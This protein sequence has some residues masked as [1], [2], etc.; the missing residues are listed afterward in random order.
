LFWPSSYGFS[1][2]FSLL[3]LV[4]RTAFQSARL[5]LRVF[6]PP[7]HNKGSFFS[8]EGPPFSGLL[9]GLGIVGFF[10]R[11]DPPPGTSGQILHRCLALPLDTTFSSS[12]QRCGAGRH[13]LSIFGGLFFYLLF[14]RRSRRGLLVRPFFFFFLAAPPV[15]PSVPKIVQGTTTLFF[16]SLLV[17]PFLRLPPPRVLCPPGP[18]FNRSVL[19]CNSFHGLNRCRSFRVPPVN[20]NVFLVF[21]ARQPRK[22]FPFFFTFP[23]P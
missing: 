20:N 21:F 22:L 5:V 1:S 23:S 17:L 3:F 7:P 14:F 9:G 2:I 12:L 8:H 10:F 15:S 4:T 16:L 6:L 13:L 11:G 19:F 18:I